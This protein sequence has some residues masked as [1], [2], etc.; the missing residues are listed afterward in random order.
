MNE[1]DYV[2]IV[3]SISKC[4]GNGVCDI[5]IGKCESDK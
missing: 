5:L 4:Y 3:V 1:H 2:D